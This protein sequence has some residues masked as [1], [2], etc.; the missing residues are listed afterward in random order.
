MTP[1]QP[2]SAR[3]QRVGVA[4]VAPH[5]LGPARRPEHAGAVNLFDERVVEPD[6]VAV[7]QKLGRHVP[8]DE[9]ASAG[10]EQSRHDDVP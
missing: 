8:S 2:R 6:L 7:R 4:H 1:S 5:D 10:D 9:P 3:P